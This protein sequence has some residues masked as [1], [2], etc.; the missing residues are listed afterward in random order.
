MTIEESGGGVDVKIRVPPTWM[1]Y[2]Q[3]VTGGIMLLVAAAVGLT[4]RLWF[5]LIF[6]V[7]GCVY[8]GLGLAL[9]VFGVDLT[10]DFAVVRGFRRR[11]VPWEEVQAVISDDGKYGT[12]VVRLILDS[13]E[14]VRLPFPNSY[15]RKENVQCK[16]D[17]QRI[18]QCWI[19]HR[20][21][22]WRPVHPETP[23]PPT[24][25]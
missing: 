17:F 23:Q 16:R 12:A 22:S 11:R 3:F 6:L 4:G 19:T 21:E 13:G 5:A 7:G 25:R 8:V 9:R 10:P 2:V 14:S 20:G 18:D 24:H 15:W 1:G